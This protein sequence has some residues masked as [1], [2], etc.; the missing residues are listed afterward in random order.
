MKIIEKSIDIEKNASDIWNILTEFSSYRSWNPVVKHAAIYGPVVRGT[1]IRAL[2]GKWDFE[3]TIVEAR[4]PEILK[5]RGSSVG[6]NLEFCFNIDS[7][8]GKSAVRI[9]AHTGGWISAVFKK[10]VR[11]GME[12][13]LD[14]FLN[15]LKKKVLSG[16]S[17]EIKREDNGQKQPESDNITMPTP[18]NLIYKTRTRKFK[19]GGPGVR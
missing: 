12:D 4:A 14:I 9:N 1:G 13:N 19:R 11:T 6:I 17:Y 2:A 8:D 18:F 16:T 3:F 7:R 15:S 5:L 10:R